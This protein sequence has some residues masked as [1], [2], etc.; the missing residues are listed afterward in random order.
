[1]NQFILGIALIAFPFTIPTLLSKNPP[2]NLTI[3]KNTE[4]EFLTCQIKLPEDSFL[5]FGDGQ[6][7]NLRIYP[8]EGDSFFLVFRELSRRIE[9]TEIPLFF[10]KNQEN[11]QKSKGFYLSAEPQEMDGN[12]LLKLLFINKNQTILISV[13]IRSNDE[14]LKKFFLSEEWISS[15]R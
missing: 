11:N 9:D 13:F 5:V 6:K 14:T 4:I 15:C 12:S 10:P 8:K 7:R 2:P 3:R 1:M